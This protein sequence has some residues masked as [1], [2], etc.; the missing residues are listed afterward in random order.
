MKIFMQLIL[1]V[2]LHEI[3]HSLGLRHNN[4][5]VSVMNPIYQPFQKRNIV[6]LSFYDRSK[7]QQI[8]GEKIVQLK[9]LYQ[10]SFDS[11]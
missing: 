11:F 7:I 4:Y 8:Y 2:A 10:L 6:E 1:Q 5:R 3:G 9:L